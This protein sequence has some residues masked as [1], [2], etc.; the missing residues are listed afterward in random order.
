MTIKVGDE[1]NPPETPRGVVVV[2]G[3]R[4]GVAIGRAF[5][6]RRD[7]VAC[8]TREPPVAADV[9]DYVVQVDCSAPA[10]ATI[11][12]ERAHDRLGRL[13]V[14]VLAVASMPIAPAHE[15]SD[16][17]WSSALDDGLAAPFYVLRAAL[18]HLVGGG[19]IVAV[20]STNSYLAAPGLAAYSAAKAGLD[21]LIR[22]VALDYGPLGIRANIVAPALISAGEV[23]GLAAGYPVGRVGQPED[24][25]EAV[26]FLAS[27]AA[28]FISGVTLPVDG[29]LSIGSPSA[30]LQ[31]HLR[32]RFPHFH[33]PRSP[34]ERSCPGPVSDPQAREPDFRNDQS[35]EV[36]R[37]V[38]AY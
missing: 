18:P 11:A 27:D 19:S 36:E 1:V 2:G 12:V 30:Y 10:E 33:A 6:N 17:Q 7:R 3:S 15:T 13:D 38:D 22:Q 32:A 28:Q 21:G 31:P 8:L 37:P 5:R 9:F 25:A 16:E 23:A 4:I 35:G 20:G 14:L 26:A 29:G 34:F 24:V